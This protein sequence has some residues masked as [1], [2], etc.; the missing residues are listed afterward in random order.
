MLHEDSSSTCS[1]T[2]QICILLDPLV[3][4]QW[5]TVNDLSQNLHLAIDLAKQQQRVAAHNQVAIFGGIH[6]LA[7]FLAKIYHQSSSSTSKSSSSLSILDHLQQ[8]CCLL[9]LFLQ[10]CDS[11]AI[12]ALEKIASDVLPTLLWIL[13]DTHRQEA[14]TQAVSKTTDED[15]VS[16]NNSSK[17]KSNCWAKSIIYRISRLDLALPR[18]TNGCS[19]VI[20]LQRFLH[21]Q[22]GTNGQER[23]EKTTHTSY[24]LS[25][26]AMRLLDGFA[27]HEESKLFLMDMPGLADE[28]VRVSTTLNCTAMRDKNS[29]NRNGEKKKKSGSIML[30]FFI[31]RFFRKLSWETRNKFR[32][33]KT[34]GFVKLLLTCAHHECIEIRKEA[35]GVFWMLSFDKASVQVLSAGGSTRRGDGAFRP[36][37]E[38]AKTPEL[39]NLALPALH[40]MVRRTSPHQRSKILMLSNDSITGTTTGDGGTPKED[41]SKLHTARLVESLCRSTCVNEP[42]HSSLMESLITMA[43][44]SSDTVRFW[45]AKAF[46]GQSVDEMNQFFLART[47]TVLRHVV[48][49]ATDPVIRVRECAASVL[50]QLTSHKSNA[51]VLG[52]NDHLLE[53]LLFNVRNYC[54]LRRGGVG[55][56]DE[57]T[58]I[59]GPSKKQD[60]MPSPSAVAARLSVLGMLFLASRKASRTRIAKHHDCVSALAAFGVSQDT[61]VELKQAALHGVLMLVHLL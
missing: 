13:E 54:S 7:R 21:D 4:K 3:Q 58:T 31:I 2:E 59:V 37:I 17:L 42:C 38:A 48:Q 35:L 11:Y 6:L 24:L 19:L 15:D 57:G 49:L 53:A 9:R 45:A 18:M 25:L 61:D 46:H 55:D 8:V 41:I 22:Q 44:S 60:A 29:N 39:R 52:F 26:E 51:K 56:D 12:A 30:G 23:E 10:C 32:L 36:L 50:L 14:Q 20:F 40:R 16:G 1:Y 28:V 27:R 33:A 43:A 34:K 5:E 47:P